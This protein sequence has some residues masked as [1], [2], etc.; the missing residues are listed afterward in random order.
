MEFFKG[1]FTWEAAAITAFFAGVGVVATALR[2][3]YISIKKE[4]RADRVL[5]HNHDSEESIEAEKSW[6]QVSHK[7][8]RRITLLE[9]RIDAQQEQINECVEERATLRQADKNKTEK[10]LAL[11][12]RIAYCEKNHIDLT[13]SK[14]ARIIK[15]HKEIEARKLNLIEGDNPPNGDDNQEQ[16]P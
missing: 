9:R 5:Q 3:M 16:Q 10:I 13:D 1:F 8:D 6:R 4:R 12:Q 7:Q 11:E 14:V 15:R 2:V